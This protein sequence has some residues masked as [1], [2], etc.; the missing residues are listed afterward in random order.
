MVAC[1]LPCLDR[2]ALEALVQ[3]RDSS[4]EATA[5][6]H[7]RE[8]APEPYCTIYEPAMAPRLLDAY[9]QG[10]QTSREVLCRGRICLVEPAC[11]YALDDVNDPE[12]RARALAYLE[13]CGN[14]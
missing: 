7:P 8:Q 4:S 14:T 9:R 12:G 11:S 13:R 1:D 6:R 10:E 2:D 5:Y 3:A